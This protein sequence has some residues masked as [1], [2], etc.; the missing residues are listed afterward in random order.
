MY[1]FGMPCVYEVS[2]VEKNGDNRIITGS[3]VTNEEGYKSLDIQGTLNGAA[4]QIGDVDRFEKISSEKYQRLYVR[5]RSRR[6]R[7]GRRMRRGVPDND[8][9]I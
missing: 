9:V 5:R 4:L 8:S 3:E 6:D 1:L 7:G 2:S